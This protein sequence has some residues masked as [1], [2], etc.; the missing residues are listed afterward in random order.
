MSECL[1][2]IDLEEDVS[3]VAKIIPDAIKVGLNL[4]IIRFTDAKFYEIGSKVE[5]ELD[6][7]LDQIQRA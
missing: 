5:F 2:N 4:Q 3:T 7:K 6:L 1:I